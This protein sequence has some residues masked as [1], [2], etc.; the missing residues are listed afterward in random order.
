MVWTVRPNPCSNAAMNGF[1]VDA[2]HEGKEQERRED[3]DEDVPLEARDGEKEQRDNTEQAGERDD[4]AVGDHR[5]GGRS[6]SKERRGHVAASLMIA[7]WK[8]DDWMFGTPSS[9][10]SDLLPAG[11]PGGRD[12]RVKRGTH[13]GEGCSPISIERS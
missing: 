4:H 1:S 6:L 12:S 9:A 8:Q 13:G 3:G 2:R 11:H 7:R 10:V 5:G